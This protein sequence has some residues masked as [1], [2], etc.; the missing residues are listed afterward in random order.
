[1]QKRGFPVSNSKE[2]R[3]ILLQALLL[4]VN[5]TASAVELKSIVI[6]KANLLPEE[7]DYYPLHYKNRIS[8]TFIQ[9]E[10]QDGFVKKLPYMKNGQK[11][12]EI[13]LEGKK[14]ID[15]LI[16]SKED[17]SHTREFIS[18]QW[19]INQTEDLLVDN[20]QKDFF[21]EV[22]ENNLVIPVEENNLVVPEEEI[23][24]SAQEENNLLEQY[25]QEQLSIMPE[26]VPESCTYTE[27]SVTRVLVNS[28]ERNIAARNACIRRYG[29]VCVVCEIDLEDIYGTAARGLIHIHHLKP[30]SEIGS[31]YEVDPVHDL[32][33]VCPNCHAVIHRRIPI[34]SI[35]EVKN[36]IEQQRQKG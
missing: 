19:E 18:Y 11:V 9:M 1:M 30:L 35:E 13:T 23:S 10:K 12:W 14:W 8:N 21:Q 31:D 27:G 36:L 24:Q 25:S 29:C 20:Q 17:I 7:V 26:E 28:Y 3:K 2:L 16:E 4:Q 15:E 22:E 32:Q 5:G 33:P 6:E 34:F